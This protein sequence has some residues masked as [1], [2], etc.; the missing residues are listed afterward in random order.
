MTPGELM[1]EYLAAAERGD[2]GTAFEYFADN[3]VMRVPGR[4]KLAGDHQGK[5]AAVGYIQA[6]RDHY[7]RGS[8]ELELVEMLTGEE[9]VALLVRERF[10]GDG[11]RVEI[12]RANVYRVRDDQIIEIAIFEADQYAV[13]ELLRDISPR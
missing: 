3:I 6:I 8:I 11:P 7:R 4:S 2:W 10:K 13:D 5:D 1:K 9:R 12:R